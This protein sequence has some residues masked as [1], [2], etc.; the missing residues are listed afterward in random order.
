MEKFFVEVY[1]V[2]NKSL[3]VI[4]SDFNMSF[5][6]MSLVI[7]FW[8]GLISFVNKVN[9]IVDWIKKQNFVKK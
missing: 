8:K 6:V 2:N 5:S 1:V 4:F 3:V 7:V 9:K